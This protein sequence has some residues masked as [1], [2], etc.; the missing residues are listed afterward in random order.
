MPTT[1][2]NTTTIQGST[3][4]SNSATTMVGHHLDSLKRGNHQPPR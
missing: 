3:I 2:D 1:N 4:V